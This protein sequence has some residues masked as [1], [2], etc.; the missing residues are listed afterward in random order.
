MAFTFELLESRRLLS[1][2]PW[3]L[4]GQ[5]IAQDRAAVRFPTITGAGETIAVI[6]SGVDYTHPV[7]GGG[8][9]PSFKVVDGHDFIEHRDNPYP[10]DLNMHGTATAGLA[11]GNSWI[12]DGSYFQGIAPEARLVALRA[13]GRHIQQA[14]DWVIS[15]R[16][17]YNIVAVEVLGV[18]PNWYRREFQ[19]LQADDVFVGTPSGNAGADTP[20]PSLPDGIV[21]TGSVDPDGQISSFTQ[22]GPNMNLLAPGGDV[23]V[24]TDVDG[25]HTEVVVSGTSW[26]SPQ[27]VGAAALIKEIN[28]AFTPSQILAILEQSGTPIYDRATRTTYPELNLDAALALAERQSHRMH[29]SVH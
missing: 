10:V 14:L 15:H 27:V 3:G 19:T 18:H 4:Q 8:F 21:Q 5:Q 9:G 13:S 16:L 17:R 22:R 12:F 24:P 11:A 20:A 1:G 23:V 25:E 7:L 2:S 6:D 26:A 28:S 29:R